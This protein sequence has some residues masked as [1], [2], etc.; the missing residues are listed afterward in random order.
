MHGSRMDANADQNPTEL[1]M[2]RR[3]VVAEVETEKRSVCRVS[4]IG[5]QVSS[6]KRC[7]VLAIG[8]RLRLGVKRFRFCQF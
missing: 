7:L 4:G 3:F 1:S 5:S 2:H 8:R 6:L